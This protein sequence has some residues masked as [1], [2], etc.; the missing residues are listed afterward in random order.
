MTTKKTFHLDFSNLLSCIQTHPT[1][2]CFTTNI[3]FKVR[4]ARYKVLNWQHIT[5]TYLYI[6]SKATYK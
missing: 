2:F 6:F 1:D 5:D 4:N 3:S